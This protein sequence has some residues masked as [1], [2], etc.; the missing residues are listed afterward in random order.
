M[1]AL[2][3]SAL[4]G[5]ALL[6][7]GLWASATRA[8][9]PP[10]RIFYAVHAHFPSLELPYEGGQLNRN[11]AANAA[12]TLQEMAQVLDA[13]GARASFQLT[14]GMIRGV[15]AIGGKDHVLV[16]LAGGGHDVAVHGHS[17][18]EMLAAAGA[19]KSACGMTART[20]SGLLG[21]NTMQQAGG[22]PPMRPGGPAA[23]G[24]GVSADAFVQGARKAAAAGLQV[25][26]LNATPAQKKGAPLFRLCSGQLGRNVDGWQA[27]GSL[28]RPWTPDL[29]SGDICSD[30]GQGGVTLIDHIPGDWLLVPGGRARQSVDQ[31]SDRE[32]AALKPMLRSALA[33]PRSGSVSSWGFVSHVHEYMPGT[34]G[35]SPPSRSALDALDRWL[36]WVDQIGG[37]QVVWST[38]PEIAA[39]SR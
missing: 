4:L 27:S 5:L 26:T 25:V 23:M 19:L 30:R 14:E 21:N 18:D 17:P 39:L 6:G 20:G 1:S 10:L 38:P 37:D 8:G 3:R 32:F 22:G 29:A 36:S 13:H 9:S 28:P 34:Q 2:L 31:A 35:A 24:G 11:A 15:C 7:A 12:A 33:A 16:R